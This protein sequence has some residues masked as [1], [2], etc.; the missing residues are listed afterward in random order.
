MLIFKLYLPNLSIALEYQGETHYYSSHL[1]G[2]ATERQRA[3]Q[4]KHAFATNYG[5]TVISIP[6][7]W[8]KSPKSLAATILQH[9]P[10]IHISENLLGTPIPSEMPSKF[11]A[12]LK[13]NP[14]TPMEYDDRVNPTGWYV[15]DEIVHRYLLQILSLHCSRLIRQSQ[16]PTIYVILLILMSY[17]QF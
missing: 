14:N 6:F 5:I 3:D 12:H 16:Y 8:D 2:K 4:A 17:N 9:R 10:D 1:F 11:K 15:G 7:W 13:Y